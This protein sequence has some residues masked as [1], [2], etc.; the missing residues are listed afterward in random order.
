MY[1]QTSKYSSLTPVMGQRAP[2]PLN[3]SRSNMHNSS[4]S[5]SKMDLHKFNDYLQERISKSAQKKQ[6]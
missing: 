4:E 2:S 1:T 3:A 6:M 5:R